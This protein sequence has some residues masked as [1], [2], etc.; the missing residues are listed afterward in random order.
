MEAMHRYNVNSVD[1]DMWDTEVSPVVAEGKDEEWPDLK[2]HEPP[3]FRSLDDLRTA[4]K[5]TW[6]EDALMRL[7]TTKDVMVVLT[8][9]SAKA[10]GDYVEVHTYGYRHVFF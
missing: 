2:V 1:P 3:V 9:A 7:Q 8:P 10:Q 6:N 5:A 4:A